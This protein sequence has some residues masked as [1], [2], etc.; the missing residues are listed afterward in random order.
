MAESTSRLDAATHARVLQERI[1]PASGLDVATAQDS[2]RAIVLAGQPGAGKSSLLDAA[3]EDLRQNVVSIDADEFRSYYPGIS[4]LASQQPYGWS[5]MTDAD[6]GQWAREV[7]GAALE[8][9]RNVI[10]DTTL[11][12][13]QGAV[14][15]VNTLRQ[16]GYE[17]EVRAVAAHSL[18]SELGVDARFT[19]GID[20][21]GRGRH[22]TE[23]YRQRMYEQLPS[24]LDR[25]HAETGT[26]VRIYGRDGVELYDSRTTTQ[27]PGS[28]LEAA[29]EARIQDPEVTRRTHESWRG[30]RD[31]HAGVSDGT[32]VPPRLPPETVD[33]L[34][35]DRDLHGVPPSLARNVNE[36]G[37]ADFYARTGPGVSRGLLFA[38]IALAIADTAQTT[39]NVLGHL[40]R[41]NATAAESELTHL[42][43]RTVTTAGFA[44]GGMKLGGMAGMLFGPEAAPVGAGVGGLVGGV[45]GATVGGPITEWL[46]ESKIYNQPDPD[47]NT[48]TMDPDHRER[49]WLRTERIDRTADEIENARSGPVR[50]DPELASM[51]DYQARRMSTELQIG[52]PPV[53]ADPFSQ[54]PGPGD[55]YSHQPSNWIREP[56]SGV[57]QRKVWGPFVERTPS[58]YRIEEADDPQRI[59]ELDHAAA[60]VVLDN[61]KISPAAIAFLYEEEHFRNQWQRHGSM[62]EEVVR[63]RAN[64]DELFGS[65]GHRYRRDDDGEWRSDG[66]FSESPARGNLRVELD[67]T[68]DVLRATLPPPR[69]LVAPR[70]KTGDE[71]L[72]DNIADQYAQRGVAVDAPQLDAALRAVKMVLNEQGLNNAPLGILVHS[73]PAGR[74]AEGPIEIMRVE[75]DGTYRIAATVTPDDLR[76]AAATTPSADGSGVPDQ[77]SAAPL[78]PTREASDSQPSASRTDSP[79]SQATN[80]D[81]TRVSFRGTLLSDAAH[82]NNPMFSDLLGHGEAEDRKRGRDPDGATQCFAAGLTADARDR[83]LQ[84]VKFFEMSADGTRAWLA[85]HRDPSTPWARTASCDVSQALSQSVEDSS[86]RVDRINESFARQQTLSQEQTLSQDAPTRGARLV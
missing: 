57:W 78:S 85:D 18:E 82:P 21:A 52:S 51:L 31:W 66:L 60:R 50:A 27:S 45:I 28:A 83:G 4:R 23:D 70:P 38:G 81:A 5:A 36:A 19:S 40:E 17:V 30:Q 73:G 64:P 47:G 13:G 75:P 8:G 84:S 68:S 72:R 10:I 34:R 35:I 55:T 3:R 62:P 29:R 86:A 1:L 37:R 63:L 59:R 42:G 11:G 80:G 76:R 56:E 79:F 20:D 44:Y 33:N 61:A 43:V 67:A 14:E 2:P 6:A 65:N 77:G 49:G 69:E 15:L 74:E 22:V 25:V 53:T 58:Q 41:G 54:P 26:P 7:T 48:W 16:R 39:N 9:R 24:S 46:D 71:L 12:N 32:R